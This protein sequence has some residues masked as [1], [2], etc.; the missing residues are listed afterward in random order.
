[1][2]ILYKEKIFGKCQISTFLK[3]EEYPIK[4]DEGGDSFQQVRFLLSLTPIF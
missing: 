1:M 4:Y 3:L 2:I